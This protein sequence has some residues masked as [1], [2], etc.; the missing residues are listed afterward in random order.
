MSDAREQ[1][2]LGLAKTG[3]REALMSYALMQCAKGE[4]ETITAHRDS[5][6]LHSGHIKGLTVYLSQSTCVWCDRVWYARKFHQGKITTIRQE[7][8]ER[9]MTQDMVSGVMNLVDAARKRPI[10]SGFELPLVAREGQTF[11][12]RNEDGGSALYVS[13]DNEWH[14]HPTEPTPFGAAGSENL[15]L[16]SG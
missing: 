8:I 15:G 11:L 3:D 7:H 2:L 16:Y 4:H 6:T 14:P 10:Q 12:L 9:D 13:Q 5:K 1:R